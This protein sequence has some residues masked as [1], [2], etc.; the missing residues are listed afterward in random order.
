MFH[1]NESTILIGINGEKILTE[2]EELRQEIR[3]LKSFI[4]DNLNKSE[5]EDTTLM[6][7]AEVSKFFQVNM[8][9]VRN[10]SIS[11]ILQP[12]YMGDRVYFKRSEVMNALIPAQLSIKH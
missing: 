5:P 11:G 6:T 2:F 10:W 12:Y 9:T 8:S 4:S 3:D 7:R 1:H